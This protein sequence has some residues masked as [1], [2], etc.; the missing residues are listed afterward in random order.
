MQNQYIIREKAHIEYALKMPSDEEKIALLANL[1]DG[2]LIYISDMSNPENIAYIVMDMK[3]VQC[4]RLIVP[5]WVVKRIV[6]GFGQF[7][8]DATMLLVGYQIDEK[9]Y[10][11]C[12]DKKVRNY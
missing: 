3:L 10:W 5:D 8:Q 6:V 1:E 2:D 12:H 11:D 7:Y 4:P 9:Q